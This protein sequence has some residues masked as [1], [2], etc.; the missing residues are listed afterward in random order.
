MKIEFDLDYDGA[1]ILR[2]QLMT[3]LPTSGALGVVIDAI[4]SAIQS[5][6]ER[7]YDRQQERLMESG[8]ADDSKY[9]R[10]AVPRDCGY[11]GVL[12][13]PTHSHASFCPLYIA[14]PP[15]PYG[16]DGF[17]RDSAGRVAGFAESNGEEYMEM[18]RRKR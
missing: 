8:R 15:V 12:I 9:R 13:A 5:E 3:K 16:T 17:V 10:D 14:P 18:E 7:R 2:M 4:E 1:K 11:C 6:D